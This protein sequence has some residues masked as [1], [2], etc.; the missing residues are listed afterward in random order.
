M[1]LNLN[2]KYSLFILLSHS[3]TPKYNIKYYIK[4][5]FIFY[6]KKTIKP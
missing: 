3:L 1:Y 4:Y 6:T 5:Y 2:H